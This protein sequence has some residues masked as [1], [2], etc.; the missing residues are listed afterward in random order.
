MN[1]VVMIPPEEM[2]QLMNLYKERITSDPFLTDATRL[3]AKR[4]KV[5]ASKKLPSGIKQA[6]VKLL[7]PKISRAIKKYKRGPLHS[8]I[9]DSPKEDQTKAFEELLKKILRGKPAAKISA[10]RCPTKKRN[11]QKWKSWV[12]LGSLINQE[13]EM[14]KKRTLRK[15][16]T[17]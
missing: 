5:L 4:H 14:P 2:G 10:Y 11:F 1:E 3:A 15:R 16:P 6:K 9:V 7:G 17:R 8:D 13:Q 12:V